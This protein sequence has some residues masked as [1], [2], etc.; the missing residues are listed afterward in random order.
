MPKRRKSCWID[1]DSTV[2]TVYGKKK[3]AKKGFNS[4]RKGAV[5][6]RPLL[7][8]RSHTKE[9]VRG[10]LGPGNVYTANGTVGFVG[11]IRSRFS[12]KRL[13]P[14][15]G[16][17]FFSGDFLDLPDRNGSGYPIEVKPKNLDD[18]PERQTWRLVRNQPGYERCRF[19]Y[20]CKGWSCTGS[21]VAI[22]KEK[23]KEIGDRI[24]FYDPKE[25][26][27]FRYVRSENFNPRQAHKTY[28]EQ[29]TCETWIEESKNRTALAHIK[30]DYFLAS[31]VI[32]QCAI[33]AYN[34]VRR[35]AALSDNKHLLLGETKSSKCFT[36]RVAGRSIG[37]GW[38]LL[39]DTPKNLSYKNQWEIRLRFATQRDASPPLAINSFDEPI[40][41]TRWINMR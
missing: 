28:G 18:L 37:S 38:Q 1:I 10:L 34:I 9:I 31:A 11:Q 19:E 2:K 6:Y 35:M 39:L 13:V 25:Y 24:S 29:A 8:F 22:R 26:E 16:G 7:A 17:G 23:P 14:R 20:A 5:S 15:G 4:K 33:P 40:F 36:I 12:G 41:P 32:F 27:T 30:T 21:L 3:G